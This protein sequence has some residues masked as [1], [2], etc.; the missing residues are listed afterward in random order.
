MSIEAGFCESDI[1]PNF[2]PIRTYFSSATEVMDPIFAHAAVY[3]AGGKIL[4]FLSLDVVIVEWEYVKRIR[5]QVASQRD[6]SEDAIMVCATHQG[7]ERGGE[8]VCGQPGQ[9][10]AGVHPHAP[11]VFTQGGA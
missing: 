8:D 2:F 4:A 1:S 11:G 6:I 10:L 3:Q 9:W 7:G 5:Q